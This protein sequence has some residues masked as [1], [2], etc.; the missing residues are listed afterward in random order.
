MKAQPSEAMPE[1]L[2]RLERPVGRPWPPAECFD[3]GLLDG[4]HPD[5][6][7]SNH[8]SPLVEG[9]TAWTSSSSTPPPWAPSPSSSESSAGVLALRSP[10]PKAHLQ[11]AEGLIRRPCTWPDR[12]STTKSQVRLTRK[13]E[14]AKFDRE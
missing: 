5:P 8:R 10:R 2:A 9:Q 1:S 7:S 13:E 4:D 14:N 11:E 12:V 3:V 6:Q